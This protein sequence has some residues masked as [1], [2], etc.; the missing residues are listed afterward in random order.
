MNDKQKQLIIEH[1]ENL[2]RIFKTGI[3]PLTLCKKQ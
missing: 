3:E 1:G 2:N